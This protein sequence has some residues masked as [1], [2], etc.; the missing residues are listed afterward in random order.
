MNLQEKS[1]N[2]FDCGVAFTFSVEEQQ[3]YQAK[4]HLHIPKRCPSCRQSRKVR[5]SQSSSYS[6]RQPGFR[7]EYRLF[8]A[9]C[10]QCGQSTQVPFEPKDGRPVYCRNCFQTIK[11]NR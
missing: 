3:D 1:V 10:A 4:G 2:C 11:V 8:P 6:N 5:Q 9:T 7:P